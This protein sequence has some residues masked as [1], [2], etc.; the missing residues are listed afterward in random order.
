MYRHAYG[1]TL[2]ELLT[3]LSILTLLATV[4]V[5]GAQQF[6]G[7]Q[8]LVSASNTL[9]A[10]L[11]LARSESIKRRQPV[12]VDNVD[13][14]WASGW[15]V[16]VDLDNN[17]QLD[18]GEPLLRQEPSLPTGVIA[19]GNT[20]VRRYVRYT[21]LGNAKLLGG[22]F[23]AGTLTLCHATGKQAVRRLVLSASGRLRRARDEPDYC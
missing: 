2:V 7:N 1:F 13:G 19:K 20:P 10:N 12:L 14:D 9:A 11:S 16:F 3:S 15:R 18:E 6:L 8:Q 21:P 4:G 5:P 23:Q 17:G 22:A